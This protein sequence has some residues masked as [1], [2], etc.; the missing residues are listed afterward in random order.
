[1]YERGAYARLID[2]RLPPPPPALPEAEAAWLLAM[3]ESGWQQHANVAGL[4]SGKL[5]GT[6][7]EINLNNYSTGNG[8]A[9]RPLS[10]YTERATSR[11]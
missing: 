5:G 10:A 6:L 4:T 8:L 11:G 7:Q 1:M 3:S 9:P 2:Y